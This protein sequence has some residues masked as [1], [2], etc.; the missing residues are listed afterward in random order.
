MKEACF[1]LSKG[2]SCLPLYAIL[3]DKGILPVGSL[4]R[5]CQDGGLPGHP[6]LTVPGIVAETGSLGHGLGIA[7]GMALAG[8]PVIV[9]IGDGELYEGSTWEA[10]SFIAH[11]KLDVTLVIDRNRQIVCD[12]TED[13]N[14]L[15]D[16]KEKL[17]VFRWWTC[18]IDGHDFD[19][20]RAPFMFPSG[21]PLA[22]IANTV[23]GK[24]VS[25][26]EHYLKWHHSIPT[27][28]EY[29]LARKELGG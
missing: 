25:F 29:E 20:I 4:D 27:Q 28:E 11:H 22:I 24:G 2:H 10:I 16:V 26:M 19:E 14:A 17:K 3:E 5:F 8:Q 18:E 15:G 1:I 9:L 12:F 6:D 7:A 23:K 21:K 13:I